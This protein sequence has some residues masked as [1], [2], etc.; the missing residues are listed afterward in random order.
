[1][2]YQLNAQMQDQLAEID[3]DKHYLG[4]V[5][6][7]YIYLSPGSITSRSGA[8]PPVSYQD[9][10]LC[11]RCRGAISIKRTK[12]LVD[13][14]TCTFSDFVAVDLRQSSHLYHQRQVLG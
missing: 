14:T 11:G 13:E 2:E 4:F 3:I 1:M 12:D 9:L 10:V 8:G 7:D 6:R 5:F